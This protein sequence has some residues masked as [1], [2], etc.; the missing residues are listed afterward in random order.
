MAASILF[1]GEFIAEDI[2]SYLLN[3][4]GQAGFF[5]FRQTEEIR[6]GGFRFQQFLFPLQASSMDQLGR[7]GPVLIWSS[8]NVP[9]IYPPVF[10]FS[11]R[12]PKV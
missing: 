1:V 6:G 9:P 10:F 5:Y 2:L 8:G 3:Y 12:K 7:K 11:P 4:G